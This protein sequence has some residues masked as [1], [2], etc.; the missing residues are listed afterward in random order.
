M[1]DTYLVLSLYSS[2]VLLSLFYNMSNRSHRSVHLHVQTS[3]CVLALCL[4]CVIN[5]DTADDAWQLV[6]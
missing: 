5:S 3:S 1:Q 2:P 4:Q 6:L